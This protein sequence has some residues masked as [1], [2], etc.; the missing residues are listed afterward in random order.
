[1]KTSPTSLA[2]VARVCDQKQNRTTPTTRFL[3]SGGDSKTLEQESKYGQSIHKPTHR[4]KKS[5][6][7]PSPERYSHK[8]WADH[9]QTTNVPNYPHKAPS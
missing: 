4:P 2:R 6:G 9:P 3:Y 5:S 8:G 7:H 1:M